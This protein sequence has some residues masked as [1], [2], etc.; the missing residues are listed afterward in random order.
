[1]GKGVDVTPSV[2][3]IP[4]VPPGL[5]QSGSLGGF[6]PC[7]GTSYDLAGDVAGHS[8]VAG[9]RDSRVWTRGRFGRMKG[10]DGLKRTVF[11]SGT[12][13]GKRT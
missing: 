8:G 12:Q 3:Y 1:L 6:A 4:K 13:R 10:T 11:V 5:G 9:G 7:G 2:R